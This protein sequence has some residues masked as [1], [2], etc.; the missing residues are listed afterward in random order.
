[1]AKVTLE[2]VGK[3]HP[4]SIRAVR[5]STWK[6]KTVN[7]SSWSGPRMRKVNGAQNG[8]GAG[9]ISEGTVKIGDRVVSS[10]LPRAGYRVVPKLR[11]PG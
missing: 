6:S 1:M 5:T 9:E 7:S 10:V 8:R 2:H 3:I 4:G 11:S